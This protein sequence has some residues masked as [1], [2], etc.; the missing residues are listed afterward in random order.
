MGIGCPKLSVSLVRRD[1]PET[2]GCVRLGSLFSSSLMAAK[3]HSSYSTAVVVLVIAVGAT[4]AGLFFGYL[5]CASWSGLGAGV[6]PWKQQ[7]LCLRF[8]TCR[9]QL[10]TLSQDTAGRAD[11]RRPA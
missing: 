11:A 3:A 10:L 7:T 6:W 9:N 4:I 8:N 2:L 5:K 1:Y